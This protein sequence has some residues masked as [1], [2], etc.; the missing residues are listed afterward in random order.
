MAEKDSSPPRVLRS[1]NG[2]LDVLEQLSVEPGHFGVTA[3]GRAVKLSKAAV[4]T[5][6]K[7]LERRGYVE[8]IEDSGE[9]RLG[10]RSWE[11]G[12]AAGL[13]IPL[14]R[15]AKPFLTELTAKTGESAHLVEY[16]RGEI[17]YLDK[18]TSPNHVQVITPIGGRAPAHCVATGKAILAFLD[19][20]E[21]ERY[22]AG[23]LHRYTARTITDPAQ[24]ERELSVIRTRGYAL[25]RGEYRGEIV[26]VAAPIMDSTG[27]VAAAVSVAGPDYRFSPEAAEAM[28]GLITDTAK[29]ISARLGYGRPGAGGSD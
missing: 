26:A 5:V 28:A 10:H 22:R 29:A 2:A 21:V 19:P 17:V 18:V 6:L 15:I 20:A 25:N 13:H 16:D 27:R 14:L 24:L 12:M 23:G 7:N 9:Y 1:V 8:Q 4:H 11:L 3:I